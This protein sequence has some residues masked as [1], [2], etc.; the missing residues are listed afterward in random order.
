MVV[1]TMQSFDAILGG[2]FTI[3]QPSLGYRFGIDSIL[4]AR[5][6]QP[7][8]H[9]RV[10]ELGAGCGVVAVVL[11]ALHHPSEVVAVELQPQLAELI[12]QNAALNQIAELKAVCADIRQRFVPGL[13]PSAFDYIVANPPY[14]APRSGRESPDPARRIARAGMGATLQDFLAAAVRY[15]AGSGRVALIFTA[16]RTAELIAEMKRRRLEPKRLRF[17]HPRPGKMATMVLVEARKGGGGET[18]V[19]PPLFLFSEPG[20][21]TSEARELLACPKSEN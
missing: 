4:L 5:F 11:A 18:I 8:P 6:A 2:A 3:I 17:V 12:A 14:R 1:N 9:A 13:A 16:T 19:E 7:Q 21:Y 15:A 20:V 10:L